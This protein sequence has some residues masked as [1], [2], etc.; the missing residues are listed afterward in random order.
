M[1]FQQLQTDFQNFPWQIEPLKKREKNLM[2]SWLER[3]RDEWWGQ[4]LLFAV[5]FW[6]SCLI[7]VG[8]PS[9]LGMSSAPCVSCLG[10]M[11]FQSLSVCG[12]WLASEQMFPIH[13]CYVTCF[14]P[15]SAHLGVRKHAVTV[16]HMVG[17]SH[18]W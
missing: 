13:E 18:H 12:S 7:S 1:F 9:A 4:D 5:G 16:G 6:L 11:P 8:P 14:H 2:C 10:L 3:L 17:N 15:S